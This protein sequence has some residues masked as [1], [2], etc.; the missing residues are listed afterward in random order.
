MPSAAWINPLPL[1]PR[2]TT[3]LHRCPSSTPH[4]VISR[5]GMAVGGALTFVGRCHH[6]CYHCHCS[7]CRHSLHCRYHRHRASATTTTTAIP[8][9]RF[10]CG[11]SMAAVVVLP[12]PSFT[13]PLLIDCC[14]F[15]L[16]L[17]LPPPPLSSLPPPMPLLCYFCHC[18]LHRCCRHPR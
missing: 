13:L 1:P 18:H 10:A 5:P 11:P 16:L 14:L 2:T 9:R 15:A 6:P 3:A 8:P 4:I 17:L 12:P 7:C